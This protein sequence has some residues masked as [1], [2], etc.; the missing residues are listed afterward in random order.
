MKQCSI[1]GCKETS[2]SNKIF[3]YEHFTVVFTTYQEDA[4]PS[5]PYF[6]NPALNLCSKCREKLL[7]EET[8]I[9]AVGA[10][11]KNRYYIPDRKGMTKRDLLDAFHNLKKNHD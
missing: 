8:Y 7:Q 6:G 10:M 3:E 9:R 4:A 2:E 5:P 11:G 1:N